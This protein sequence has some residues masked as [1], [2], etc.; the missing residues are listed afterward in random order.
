MAT[1]KK[2]KKAVSKKKKVVSKPKKKIAKAKK[3][4]AKKKKSTPKKAPRLSLVVD[5]PTTQVEMFDVSATQ[6]VPVGEVVGAIEE[7]MALDKLTES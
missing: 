4:I 2:T 5:Q 3:P 1:R 7:R 6:A